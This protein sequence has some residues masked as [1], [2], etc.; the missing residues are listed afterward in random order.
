MFRRFPIQ[1]GI[2]LQLGLVLGFHSYVWKMLV[3]TVRYSATGQT[4]HRR[5]STSA[6]AHLRLW[7]QQGD[8]FWGNAVQGYVCLATVLVLSQA[9]WTHLY[10]RHTG[11]GP[12]GYI[13]EY[14][15]LAD[16]A[17]A[18]RAHIFPCSIAFC[19]RDGEFHQGV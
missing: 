19:T 8:P 7:L 1:K 4:L 16:F 6:P 15:F 14:Q 13:V 12:A 5:T 2:L 3:S 10:P 18:I 9:N 11:R 17:T